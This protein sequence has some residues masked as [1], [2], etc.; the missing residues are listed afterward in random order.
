LPR[1]ESKSWREILF[2]NGEHV[3]LLAVL[4]E[5]A[6]FS[7]IARNFF[8][9][10]NFWEVSRF[11]VELGLLTLAETAVIVTGGIDLSVGSMMGL[12]AVVFG[13][14]WRDAHLSLA[15]SAAVALL[16]GLAGG[17]LN[18]LLIARWEL[19]ALI[20]TLGTYSLFRG[21]AEGITQGAAVYTSFPSSFLFLGQGY[22]WRTVP[23]QLPIFV[24]VFAGYF[25]YLHLSVDGRALYAI[26]NSPDGA[27]YAGIPVRRRLATVYILAGV[28]SSL[29]GII[30]VAHVGQATSATGAGYELDAITAVVLGGTSIFGGRGTLWGSL[31][32]LF[33]IS[34][35]Q[36]GLQLA[37]LPSELTGV[38]TG[39]LLVLVLSFD[40]LRGR[41]S[42]SVQ[43]A[44]R[45]GESDLVKNSQVAVLAAA[46]LAGSLIVALTNVWLVRS[47][48]VTAESAAV[49]GSAGE[50]ATTAG[51]HKI[52][53]A[54]M[55]KDTGDPYF[56]SC[57]TGAEQA[58]R[59]LGINL[60]WDGPTSLDA[61]QQNEIAQNWITRKVNV[62]AVAVANKAGI[63]TVLRQA[64]AQ[65]IGVVTWDS[66][67][68]ANARNYFVNQA[69]PRAI[70]YTLTDEAARLMKGKG[71]F[72]IITGTLSAEN[73]NE[74]IAFIKQR[75]AAKYPAMKLA[76]VLP[77][78]DDRDKAFAETQTILK[79]YPQVRL[80]MAISAPA[81]PGA[82]EAVRQS[83][84][85]NVFVIGLSLPS[86][87]K[88]YIHDGSVQAIV[89]WNTHHLGYA[90]VY[91]A[92]L[93]AEHKIPP[94]ATSIQAGR[95]GTLQVQGSQII[96][97]QPL[98][99][100]KKNIDT[101]NF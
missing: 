24:L 7:L 11:S 88:T 56:M 37:A 83:G 67:A 13:A 29:A 98:I 55:P 94:G 9:S 19:P 31:L 39:A 42:R 58:A 21:I 14:C 97:G 68:D 70:A 96:L 5:I 43:S 84:R 74:W 30:F 75:I 99:I 10:E 32:G 66:D 100:D 23:A 90:T 33:A 87:C 60:I 64:R 52:T 22:L 91:A 36:N 35:L 101:L 25:V 40:W 47:L 34:V 69:T 86:I 92:Y 6:V 77:S 48:R 2:P 93:L 38:M 20:V 1:T 57:R 50:A 82:G 78:D 45:T 27:R 54:M 44:S 73:Q 65:G 8:T 76:T 59:E 80:V 41:G 15:A 28:V 89:L 4:L 12:A 71:Q 79:V 26:G 16:A 72:A 63:S 81:V 18:A 3:L 53:I 62:M 51:N 49:P 17:A 46:F 85:K 95:L 61:A